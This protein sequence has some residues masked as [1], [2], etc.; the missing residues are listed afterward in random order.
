MSG[1][2]Y[3]EIL[4]TRGESTNKE[5]LTWRGESTKKEILTARGESGIESIP[6]TD[7]QHELRQSSFFV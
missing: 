4:T 1:F 6:P 5:I 3:L 2:P 7:P